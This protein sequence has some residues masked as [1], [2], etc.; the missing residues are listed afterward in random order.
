MNYW[1]SYA[2][3][4]GFVRW[5]TRGTIF[6]Y[7]IF[8]PSH[9]E[10]L[11]WYRVELRRGMIYQSGGAFGSRIECALAIRAFCSK[12]RTWVREFQEGQRAS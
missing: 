9:G 7:C 5:V 3:R 1:Q 2:Q 8:R 12:V 6:R 10:G 4:P 11:R